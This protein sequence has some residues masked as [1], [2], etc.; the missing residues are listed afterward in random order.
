MS[1]ANHARAGYEK[2]RPLGTIVAAG[3]AWGGRIARRAIV[4]GVT[5]AGGRICLATSIGTPMIR[6]DVGPWLSTGLSSPLHFRVAAVTCGSRCPPSADPPGRTWRYGA[7]GRRPLSR[8]TG[9]EPV[10]G[11]ADQ[12]GA[13]SARDRCGAVVNMPRLMATRRAPRAAITRPRGAVTR[14]RTRS[15]HHVAVHTPTTSSA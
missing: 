6:S 11:P 12:D 14:P 7:R 5:L 15:P 13:P 2:I 4:G 9:F 1:R 3:F 8:R 10:A